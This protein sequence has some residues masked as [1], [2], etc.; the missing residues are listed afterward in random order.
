MHQL[1]LLMD[2]SKTA[3]RHRV[4]VGMQL[5]ELAHLVSTAL[6]LQA[7]HAIQLHILELQLRLGVLAQ[8][9]RIH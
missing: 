3:L 5:W 2:A 9:V 8:A 1:I 6:Q 4:E 7:L